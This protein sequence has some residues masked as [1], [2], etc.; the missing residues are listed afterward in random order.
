MANKKIKYL[1][2][3]KVKKLEEDFTYIILLSERNIGKS[4]ATKSIAVKAAID[5]GGEEKFIYLR[6]FESDCK[7]SLCVNYF[8]D[9]P[10]YEMTNGKYDIIDVYRKGIYLA[11][12]DPDTGKISN[13]KKIGYCHALSIAERYKSLMFPDVKRIIYEEF[14]SKSGNYLTQNEPDYLMDYVSTIFRHR[15]GHVYLIGNK[16]SRICPYF[17]KWELKGILKQQIGTID[18]YKYVDEDGTETKL[19]VYSCD[20]LGYN[21]GMFFGHAAKN[22]TSGAYET[23]EQPHLEESEKHFREIYKCVVKFEDFMWICKFLKH[24]SD[25]NRYTWYV[26]PKTD[27]KIKPGTRVI[28]PEYSSNVLWSQGFYPLTENE[29]YIFSFLDDGKIAF[30]DNLTGTEFLNVLKNQLK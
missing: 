22:I 4:Y 21:T 10:I 11:N 15:T 3:K 8:A 2:Q 30:S 5:S 23:Q 12:I 1:D 7:D 25:P 24:V 14:I 19:G 28:C 20:N 29:R 9:L 26:I 6:R 16:I 18:T 13:R 27:P 17:R